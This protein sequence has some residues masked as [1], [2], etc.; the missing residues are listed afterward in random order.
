MLPEVPRAAPS[1]LP[2]LWDL[3]RHRSCC[4]LCHLP[5]R[6]LPRAAPC[7][8]PFLMSQ[9]GKGKL[10][11]KCKR[12]L[13]AGQSTRH[14]PSFSSSSETLWGP[15]KAHDP[16]PPPPPV[17]SRGHQCCQ[18][19]GGR[20]WARRGLAGLGLHLQQRGN[21]V[22]CPKHYTAFRESAPK[23]FFPFPSPSEAVS[24]IQVC[25]LG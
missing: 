22:R 20:G 11:S 12:K 18:Q 13:R 16:L 1:L 7:P 9:N 10:S 14:A 23:C 25:V 5:P 21:A 17:C 2:S 8:D 24:S 19:C 15:M 6:G 3:G 4:L